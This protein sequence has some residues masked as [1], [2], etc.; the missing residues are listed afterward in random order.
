MVSLFSH[1][2]GDTLC[3]QAWC[4]GTGNIRPKLWACCG[5]WLRLLSVRCKQ[6]LDK[7]RAIPVPREGIVAP[8]CSQQ[9]PR[10]HG[11]PT[12]A[13]ADPALLPLEL[14]FS[15][16]CCLFICRC[17]K[18]LGRLGDFN[19][20]AGRRDGRRLPAPRQ[21]ALINS[22]PQPPKCSKLKTRFAFLK[23]EEPKKKKTTQPQPP[24]LSV[25]GGVK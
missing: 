19:L 13:L 18:G 21:R 1:G 6:C 15:A 5:G 2:A 16:L 20:A 12:L 24:L 23:N 8:S 7:S 17:L 11:A 25:S 10:H 4:N 22:S 14:R 3:S 9:I